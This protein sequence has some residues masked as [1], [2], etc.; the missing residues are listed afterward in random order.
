MT[1]PSHLDAEVMSALARMAR[2]D[3]SEEPL[4]SARLAALSGAPIAR[5]PCPPFLGLAWSLRAN[6]AVRDALYIA[7]ARRLG[8]KLV[9]ADQRLARVPPSVLGVVVQAV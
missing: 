9:T 7:L 4:V 2:A 5:Y 6:V 3:P 8:A 1:A